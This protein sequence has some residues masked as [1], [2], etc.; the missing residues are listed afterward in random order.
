MSEIHAVIGLSQFRRLGGF[1][2]NRQN[3]ARV[4]DKGL[5][6]MAKVTPLK[7]PPQAKSNYYKY[8]AI[9][10]KGLDRTAIKKAL[11]EKYNVG[12]SGEV[13]ELPC[14]LQPVFKDTGGYKEGDYPVAEDLCQRMVC[15][16]VSAVMTEE[17]AE[18]VVDS[19]REVLR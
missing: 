10:D 13:Y 4:F 14:H 8:V 15:L 16:P 2:E 17:E 5:A 7:I 3:V 12:F 19:L 1:I 11:K 18:Y 6:K 9:L